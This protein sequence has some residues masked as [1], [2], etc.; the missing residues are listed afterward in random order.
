MISLFLAAALAGAPQP[1]TVPADASAAARC[2]LQQ[3]HLP[4]GKIGPV[5]TIERC[6][7]DDKMASRDDRVPVQTSTATAQN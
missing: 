5:R 1:Q 4:A 7:A 3:V 6:V 2:H